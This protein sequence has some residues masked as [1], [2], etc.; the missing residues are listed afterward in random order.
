MLFTINIDGTYVKVQRVVRKNGTVYWRLAPDFWDTTPLQDEVRKKFAR[1]AYDAFDKSRDEVI[2]N[3][4]KAFEDFIP[5]RKA[6]ETK[7]MKTI[8]EIKEEARH[9]R[10]E[11]K[12]ASAS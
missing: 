12:K 10:T 4:Q 2:E 1:A 9:G 3:V 8:R 6:K 11:K 5:A 7:L